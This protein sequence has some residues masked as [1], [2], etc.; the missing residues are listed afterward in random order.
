M[1]TDVL[2]RCVEIAKTLNFS[3]VAG[4]SFITQQA[5]SRQVANLEVQLGYKLFERG[6]HSIQVTPAGKDFIAKT[7]LA[8]KQLDEAVRSGRIIASGKTGILNIGYFGDTERVV[9]LQLMSK[10]RATVPEVIVNARSCT[11]KQGLEW[12]DGF[13][14][15]IIM[16]PQLSEADCGRYN[17]ETL[18]L[19]DVCVY[20]SASSPLAQ[21]DIL[22]SEDLEDQFLI[23]QDL[24][25]TK[26]AEKSLSVIAQSI[27]GHMP[28][29][30]MLTTDMSSQNMLVESGQGYAIART[31][32]L[33][34]YKY[35][36][37]IVVKRVENVQNEKD[38]MAFLW[39]KDNDNKIVEA[40]IR[41][42][43]AMK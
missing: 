10:L 28:E 18:P 23:M 9:F 21:K 39:R 41:L 43:R 2:R 36:P 42:V 33:D 34:Y 26:E 35:N 13:L 40:F 5:L 8:L 24:S 30:V 15:D 17:V 1:D 16:C 25:D 11:Y 19:G 27:L 29:R 3:K 20:I 4:N 38:N 32:V 7:E 12:L 14:V 31:C 37:N 6:Y 22:K